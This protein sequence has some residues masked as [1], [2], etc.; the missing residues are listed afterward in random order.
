MLQLFSL[1]NLL[2]HNNWRSFSFMFKTWLSKFDKRIFYTLAV[3]SVTAAAL[4]FAAKYNT[5][6]AQV[7]G[8][9]GGGKTVNAA[10]SATFNGTGFGN[11]P[12]R[13]VAGCAD[14][15]PATS[16]S[17]TFNVTGLSGSVNKVEVN[18]LVFGPQVHT[19]AGDVKAILIAPNGATHSLFGRTGAT[20]STACG[21][22][23][24]LA[25]PYNFAD[26][27]AAPPS[28]GW[29]QASAATPIPTGD[30]RTTGVGGAGATNPMPATSLN[31][32]F[33]GV[34]S[35]NGTWTL[36]FTDHGGSDTGAVTSAN[37]LVETAAPV[38]FDTNMD[39]NG[40]GKTDWV[41]GRATAT[42]LSEGETFGEMPLN[43]G[44]YTIRERMAKD[45]EDALNGTN[46]DNALA[47]PIAW[48]TS[49]N[50]TGAT[51][52]A[53]FG[54]AATDF[55]VPN[56][57]D[58]DGKTDLAVWRPGA[59]FTAAFYILKSTDNTVR[60]DIFGQTGDDP[61]ITGDYDGDGKADT[62]TFRCPAFGAGDGQCFFYYRPSNPA[63]TPAGIWV[64][65]WGFGEDGDFFVSPGDF[66]GDGKYDFCLQRAN[67][68]STTTGQFVLLKSNGFGVEY[69]NWGSS[70]D[71][72]IPGDYDGDGRS[73]F[74]VRRTISGARQHFILERDGGGTGPLSP[75]PWGITGDTSA[76]GDYDGDGKQDLA[77]WRPNANAAQNFFYVLRSSDSQLVAFEWGQQNDV[78]PASWYVH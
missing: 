36:R 38:P 54:D 69:I 75:I 35:P 76:P 47:P 29:W 21:S 58:G 6:D 60:T 33:T 19:W 70:S 78:P 34:A 52:V 20:T 67:P 55:F 24:D 71:F 41:V 66:D 11:I 45:R 1:Y 13:G 62:A 16:L 5:A 22:A 51:Q 50:G 42:P 56:D 77:V 40:D 2:A 8:D 10:P 53:S 14:A 18:N 9:N 73:D 64:V 44:V 65:P 12:D 63:V 23:S 32:S 3:L 59:P 31:P 28:G 39:M 43:R 37:L 46:S 4:L 15:D 57:Y 61:A 72:I 68:T 27:H 26:D 25:G 49:I 74:C 48:Y 30:Y 7:K 17:V